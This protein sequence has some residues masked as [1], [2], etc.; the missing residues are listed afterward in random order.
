MSGKGGAVQS[1][2][3]I[4][5]S[6]DALLGLCSQAELLFSAQPCHEFER[7]LVLLNKIGRM[8]VQPDQPPIEQNRPE[9]H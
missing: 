5:T 1:A 4:L 9:L 2:A 8:S 3:P 7:S 6:Y